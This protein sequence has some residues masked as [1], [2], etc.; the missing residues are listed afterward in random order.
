MK[1]MLGLK[2][3]SSGKILFGE[4]MSSSQIG[5]LP[6]QSSIQRDF[7]A[8]VKEVVFSGL[9]SQKKNSIFLKKTLKEKAYQNMKKTPIQELGLKNN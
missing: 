2:D 1:A 5:Y 9:L 8:S 6:Q 4:N 7:P 3:V